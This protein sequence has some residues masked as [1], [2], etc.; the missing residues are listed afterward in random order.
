[1]V[2]YLLNHTASIDE[3]VATLGEPHLANEEQDMAMY[4][5]KDYDFFFYAVDSNQMNTLV[6]RPVIKDKEAIVELDLFDEEGETVETETTSQTQ[7][8]STSNTDQTREVTT[9]PTPPKKVEKPKTP[10]QTK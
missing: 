2:S 6:V 8:N 1:E 9:N 10:E 5:G 7:N 3:L 4:H